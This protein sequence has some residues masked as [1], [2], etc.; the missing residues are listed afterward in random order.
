MLEEGIGNLPYP[1]EDEESW[2]QYRH[3]NTSKKIKE[4]D[5]QKLASLTGPSYN[6]PQNSPKK[7][8]FME[9]RLR[10]DEF[11]LMHS[12][13]SVT[14]KTVLLLADEETNDTEQFD[15]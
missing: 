1:I 13:S 5:A 15:R 7:E 4:I 11:Q 3:L 2:Q 12:D 6:S 9:E 8:K 14:G 10:Q